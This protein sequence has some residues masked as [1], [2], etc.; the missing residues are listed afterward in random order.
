IVSSG[1]GTPRAVTKLNAPKDATHRWPWFLPDGR[2][3]LYMNPKGALGGRIF[4]AAIDSP[5]PKLILED[6]SNVVY[7]RS[8][9]LLFS[10]GNALMAVRFDTRNLRTTGQPVTLPLGK[11]GFYPDRNQAFFTASDDGNLVYLPPSRPLTQLRWVDRGG[12]D[13]GSE[14]D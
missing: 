8:G 10:R 1:G 7:V 5:T 9:W 6:A 14:E 4:A 12:K 13:V 3:F 11:V 2:H